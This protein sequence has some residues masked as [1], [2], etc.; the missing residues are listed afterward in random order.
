MGIDVKGI[1]LTSHLS[2]AYASRT[3]TVTFGCFSS[4]SVAGTPKLRCVP[5]L[6][7]KKSEREAEHKTSSHKPSGDSLP[8]TSLECRIEVQSLSRVSDDMK[9]KECS[10]CSIVY[11]GNSSSIFLVSVK[12]PLLFAFLIQP[13]SHRARRDRRFQPQ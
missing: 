9:P 12:F 8:E 4:L 1:G 10:N 2:T 13:R 11:S 7:K 5:L 6:E 3:S